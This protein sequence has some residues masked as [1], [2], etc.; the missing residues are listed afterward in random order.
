MR[1]TWRKLKQNFL[2]LPRKEKAVK[3][4]LETVLQIFIPAF[5]ELQILYVRKNADNEVQNTV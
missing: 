3:C 4:D 1:Y 5:T 2:L